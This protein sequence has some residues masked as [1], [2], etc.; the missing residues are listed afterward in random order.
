VWIDPSAC[1]DPDKVGARAGRAGGKRLAADDL[2]FYL[3]RIDRPLTVG[4]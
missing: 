3:Y 2:T 1:P 4:L